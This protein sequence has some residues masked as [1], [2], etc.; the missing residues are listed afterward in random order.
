MPPF[1]LEWNTL[2]AGSGKVVRL[3]AHSW[4]FIR[5]AGLALMKKV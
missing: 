3:A 2:S 1:T 5:L 4:Q